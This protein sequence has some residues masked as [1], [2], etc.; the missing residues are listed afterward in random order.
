MVAG[1]AQL[2]SNPS[3]YVVGYPLVLGFVVTTGPPLG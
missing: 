2:V 1:R 3:A